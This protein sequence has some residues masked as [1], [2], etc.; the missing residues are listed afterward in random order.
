MFLRDIVMISF[1][2]MKCLDQFDNNSKKYEYK[3]KKSYLFRFYY[4]FLYINYENSHHSYI[5]SKL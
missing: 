5:E 1:K 3:I 2:Y 4:N